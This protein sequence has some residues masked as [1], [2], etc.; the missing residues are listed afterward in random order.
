VATAAALGFYFLL[1]LLLFGT[2]KGAHR[3]DA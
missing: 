1:P 2:G 3:H